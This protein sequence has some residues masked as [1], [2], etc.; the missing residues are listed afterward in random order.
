MF[1]KAAAFAA[2]TQGRPGSGRGFVTGRTR[3]RVSGAPEV[4]GEYPTGCLAEEIETPGP[5]QVRAL[6]SVAS[7]P[8]L[9]APGGPASLP[10]DRN[11]KQPAG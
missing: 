5:G 1:P 3:S 4:L 2:N 6:V 7:N 11:R 8:V 9:S 10:H